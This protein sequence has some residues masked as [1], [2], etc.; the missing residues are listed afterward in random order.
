MC[1]CRILWHVLPITLNSIHLRPAKCCVKRRNGSYGTK[2]VGD[3][4]L[5]QVYRTHLMAMTDTYGAMVE[6]WLTQGDGRTLAEH[7]WNCHF[8]DDESHLKSPATEP[9]SSVWEAGVSRLNCLTAISYNFIYTPVNCCT[10]TSVHHSVIHINICLF[11][12]KIC[13]T[14]R[15]HL[16]GNWI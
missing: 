8:I 1:R 9:G 14:G 12:F 6:W 16:I 2:G 15:A 3:V 10:E 5:G 4:L 11:Y 7:L 13:L